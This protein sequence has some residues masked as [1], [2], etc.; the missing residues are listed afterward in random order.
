[1]VVQLVLPTVKLLTD[2]KA[3][4]RPKMSQITHVQPHL[5]TGGGEGVEFL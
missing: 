3:I 2:L 4:S 1:M 5:I